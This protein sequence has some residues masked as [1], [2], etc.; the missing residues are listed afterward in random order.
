MH[1]CDR[2]M[3][4]C[5]GAVRAGGVHHRRRLARRAPSP[6]RPGAGSEFT[7]GE[8]APSPCRPGTGWE[9][10]SGEPAPSACRPGTGWEPTSGEPAPSPCRPGAGW[11]LTRREPAPFP[12]RPGSG[13]EP[14][15]GKPARGEPA[16][17]PP[18]TVHP[19]GKHRRIRGRRER[20]PR[21][22]SRGGRLG[23]AGRH[24]GRAPRAPPFH[25]VV[26]RG[27]THHLSTRL[28]RRVAQ[29]FSRRVWQAQH[30]ATGREIVRA[31]WHVVPAGGLSKLLFDRSL[32]RRFVGA[33]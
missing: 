33:A 7:R 29:R 12:C 30:P 31:S 15:S 14:T 10:T 23:V 1:P 16:R 21:A 4:I 19:A 18:D 28:S 13:W 20:E 3:Q 24:G 27:A 8:P 26:G 6:C 9:P 5:F 32:A 2:R 25:A 22:L 11:E 17:V